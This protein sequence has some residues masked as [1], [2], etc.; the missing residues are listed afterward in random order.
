[1]ASVAIMAVLALAAFR[2]PMMVIAPLVAAFAVL[3]GFAHGAEMAVGAGPFGYAA[4][5][6][7]GTALLHGIG[8]G[9]GMLLARGRRTVSAG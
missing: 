4:G 9:L 7:I 8:M 5:F 2:V 6:L 3:H 1:M